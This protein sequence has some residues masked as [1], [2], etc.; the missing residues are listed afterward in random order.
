MRRLLAL[1]ALL[2]LASCEKPSTNAARPA[3][4]AVSP[5]VAAE[6]TASPPDNWARS[7]QCAEW[8]Q[9][10][11]KTNGWN[12]GAPSGSFH[13]YSVQTHY[14]PFYRQCYVLVRVINPEWQKNKMPLFTDTFINA[15]ENRELSTCAVTTLSDVPLLC[16]IGDPD[17]AKYGDDCRACRQ[18]IEDRMN[19]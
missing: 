11:A 4:P 10:V 13:V 9:K 3:T 14:S 7:L 12:E 2:A 6:T 8:V 5:T 17:K 19:K 15:L 18:F 1:A 16:T